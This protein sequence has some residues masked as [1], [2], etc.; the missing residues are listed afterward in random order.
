MS[1]NA[2]GPEHSRGRPVFSA[3]TPTTTVGRTWSQFSLGGVRPGEAAVAVVRSFVTDDVAPEPSTWWPALRRPRPAVPAGSSMSAT[4]RCAPRRS[5][6]LRRTPRSIPTRSRRCP[7]G[8]LRRWPPRGRPAT[9][10]RSRRAFT[11][12]CSTACASGARRSGGPGCGR[13]PGCSRPRWCASS[14]CATARG[15]RAT[16]SPSTCRPRRRSC[17]PTAS[18]TG[19]GVRT[20]TAAGAVRCASGGRSHASPPAGSWSARSTTKPARTCSPIR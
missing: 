5:P 13:P 8:C 6:R 18:A 19:A 20:A 1:R 2:D 12:A 3:L 10:S 17:S 14:R 4:P 7:P 16:S 9:W 15:R 11:G